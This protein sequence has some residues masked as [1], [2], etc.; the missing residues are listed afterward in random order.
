M[1]AHTIQGL[2]DSLPERNLTTRMLDAVD[3]VSLVGMAATCVAV[4]T[5]TLGAY[6]LAANRARRW[7]RSSRAMTAMLTAASPVP[8]PAARRRSPRRVPSPPRP[9]C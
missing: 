9:S 1:S 6:A 3:A 4:I 2:M 7:L 8:P 5:A